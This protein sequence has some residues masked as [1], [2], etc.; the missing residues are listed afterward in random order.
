MSQLAYQ[1][2]HTYDFHKSSHNQRIFLSIFLCQPMNTEILYAVF[3]LLAQVTKYGFELVSGNS[4][5]IR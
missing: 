3:D 5:E 4:F 2:L 1:I